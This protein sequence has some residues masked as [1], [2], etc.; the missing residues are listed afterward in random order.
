[1]ISHQ[2][3][4][5][6]AKALFNIEGSSEEVHK[7]QE[8][9]EQIA[10]VIKFFPEMLYL[11]GCPELSIEHRIA[12]LEKVL[13]TQLDPHVKR[14]IGL[15]LKQRK[16]VQIRQIASDYHKMVVHDLKEME[17]EISSAEPLKEETKNILRA[18]LE[19]RLEKKVKFVEIIDPNLLGGF[20][21]LIH[22]QMLDL[23]I[24]GT[25]MNLK[26]QL[27]KVEL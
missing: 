9:L 23:S 6:Y 15:L 5:N 2:K 3:S 8:D 22:N 16:A 4:V 24:K 10:D 17:V 19:E 27:L 14:L 11:L 18:K 1:M 26:K 21:V 13:K 25:L 20:T 7:R 12:E